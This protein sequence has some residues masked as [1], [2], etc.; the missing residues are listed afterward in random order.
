MEDLTAIA[1]LVW[2]LK[3]L[4]ATKSLLRFWKIMMG[5][6]YHATAWSAI[7]ASHITVGLTIP[8]LKKVPM[9]DCEADWLQWDVQLTQW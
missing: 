3:Y 9:P 6:T 7:F 4:E 8:E 2:A 1:C 5:R